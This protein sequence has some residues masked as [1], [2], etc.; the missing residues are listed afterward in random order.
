[1]KDST[2]LDK[3]IGEAF[4]NNVKRQLWEKTWGVISPSITLIKDLYEKGLK[5][6]SNAAESLLY[7]D[8]ICF[9]NRHTPNP[10]RPRQLYFYSDIISHWPMPLSRFCHIEKVEVSANNKLPCIIFMHDARSEIF[11]KLLTA[12]T[13][14]YQPVQHLYLDANGAETLLSNAMGDESVY[15]RQ[16]LTFTFKAKS[17][18]T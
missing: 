3:S 1:M 13:E 8:K 2:I 6:R 9:M 5:E 18:D 11:D 12:C 14:T 10:A 16:V 15:T 4:L 7:N 17:K